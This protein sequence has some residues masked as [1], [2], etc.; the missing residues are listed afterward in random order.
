MVLG[1]EFCAGNGGLRV[2]GLG[3]ILERVTV[4]P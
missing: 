2:C 1:G 3:F 4:Y